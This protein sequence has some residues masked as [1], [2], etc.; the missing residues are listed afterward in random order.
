VQGIPAILLECVDLVD[1]VEVGG[2]T[3]YVISA[4]NQ[5][6]ATG[7]NVKI[8][9]D[10]DPG[11]EYVSSQGVTVASVNG[12]HIEFAPLPALAAKT[13]AE[14]RV[15]VKATAPAD[16]R[17]KIGMTSDQFTKPIEETES[18]NQYR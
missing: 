17:L 12:R 15:V 6:S 1:P 3:T 18:T 4:T 7:T 2:Q 9:V 10:L 16:A 11:Q 13:K 8:V 5:G 14:W